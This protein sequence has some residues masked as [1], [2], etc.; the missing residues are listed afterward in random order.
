MPISTTY[1][2]SAP[3][4]TTTQGAAVGNRE[5][6]SNELAMLAPEKTPLLSLCAKGKAS[7]TFCEWT[8]DKLD[9]V[10]TAGIAEGADVTSFDDKF[11]SRARLGNYVQIFRKPWLVSNLQ[12]AVTTA[13]PANAA[14]A[15]AKSIM[16]LKRNIEARLCS[17]SDRT[18]EDGAGTP[19]TTRGLGDWLDSAGPS[20]VPAD[21]RTP[22]ASI[23]TSGAF[24][25]AGL[26]N[27]L[28]SIFSKTGD[29]ANV[30]LLA[31][32]ALRKVIA[33]FSRI[34]DATTSSYTI[35]EDAGSKKITLA[36]NVFD[37]DFGIVNVVN[38]NPDCMPGAATNEG[39]IVN[40]SYLAFNTLI[41]MGSQQLENQGGGQRGYVEAV[42]AF[43][44]KHPQA[45]GKIA[46]S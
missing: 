14:A 43:L 16:E 23:H 13:A 41:A 42:G 3:A 26:N 33:N 22:T 21:Y 31:N 44:C 7:S 27:I 38:A 5:D 29:M 39:Y 17:N 15:Q 8:A 25:E 19:Y 1:N 46:Y 36:V 45:H 12:N 9:T 37:S 32:V 35:N 2:P 30:T 6:L 24:T 4:A 40:P 28:G 34:D 20:D 11:A 18:V 10:D